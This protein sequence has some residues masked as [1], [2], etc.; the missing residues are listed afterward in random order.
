MFAPLSC[1]RIF[2]PNCDSPAGLAL[3]QA[4]RPDPRDRDRGAAPKTRV[5][6]F[7]Y[8]KHYSS[9][10]DRIPSRTTFAITRIH[11]LTDLIFGE[12]LVLTSFNGQPYFEHRSVE[13]HT[14]T[15]R[16]IIFP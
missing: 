4:T 1:L 11:Y 5:I 8:Q 16:V 12:S 6:P 7:N 3:S 15:V 9:I 13:R 2:A 10:S 14:R